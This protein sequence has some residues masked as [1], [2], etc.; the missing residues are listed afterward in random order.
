MYMRIAI[1]GTGAM[2]LL[3]TYLLS[4]EEGSDI[5]LLDIHP[6]REETIRKEGLFVEG[7][8][9]D[10]HVHPQITVKP[11]NIGEADLVI[12]CVKSPDT[13]EAA[14][15]ATPLVGTDT[16]ILTLQNGLGNIESIEQAVGPGRAFGGTTSMGATVL[17][18]N[19]VRHAGW[20]ETIIGEPTGNKTERAEAILETFRLAGLDVSFTDNLPGLLW[21]KLI[22]NVGINA[23]TALTRVHNGRLIDHEGTRTV[24]KMAVEEAAQ[25]AQ[26]LGIRLLYDH[27]VEKV[28]GVCEA[29]AGNIASMLQDVL[30]E[31]RT[32]IEQINGAVVREAARLGIRTPVNETLLGL[33]RTLEESYAERIKG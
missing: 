18:P 6:E 22:I 16:G 7:V 15:N 27:P 11:E 19:R 12:L 4:K 32:E 5:W 17:A 25:V 20:G 1:V 28:A 10:H 13:Y 29:T 9:G 26:A 33:V 2:G 24:M 14:R 8:S 23:L 3:F 30:K 31:K 21:S